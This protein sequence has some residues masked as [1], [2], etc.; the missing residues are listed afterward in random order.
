MVLGLKEV[1]QRH[2]LS[3]FVSLC[4]FLGISLMWCQ[5]CL[6]WHT[7]MHKDITSTAYN[8][9]PT[10]LKKALFPYRESILWNSMVPDLVL[11]D[12][13]HHEWNIHRGPEDDTDGP[14]YIQFLSEG[15]IL[16]L[17]NK[18][19]S[20][21]KVA[22]SLGRL[23]HYIADLSQPLHTDD[24]LN[25]NEWIHLAYEIDLYQNKQ[26][27]HFSNKGFSFWG[28][29]KTKAMDSAA[30]ANRYYAS[31]VQEYQNGGGLDGLK[32]ISQVC[33]TNAV[34]D[35]IDLWSTIWFAAKAK[36]PV[37][38]A[39]KANQSQY[40]SGDVIILTISSIVTQPCLIG[41]LYVTVTDEGGLVWYLT[42]NGEVRQV[43]TA[44]KKGW[45]PQTRT[46]PLTLFLSTPPGLIGKSFTISAFV[47]LVDRDPWS[48]GTRLSNISRV[49][50]EISPVNSL[51]L[52][53]TGVK[54]LAP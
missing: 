36:N 30:K 43:P 13:P 17:R 7:L 8:N 47:T 32:G 20:L 45:R 37:M 41:D 15:L 1:R 48:F 9:L 54:P 34:Q 29:I 19:C 53:D 24:Y 16:C 31:I 25:D 26:F 42:S 38:L 3:T 10:E 33:F 51:Y 52:E 6:S 40:T 28:D 11:H 23:S 21:E 22:M 49:F 50:L 4:I 5:K 14:E 44:F 18:Q 46:A 27:L 35:I 39:V 12:W 2:F